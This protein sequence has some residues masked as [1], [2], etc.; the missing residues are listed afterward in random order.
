MHLGT[1]EVNVFYTDGQTEDSETRTLTDSWA[2]GLT[3]SQTTVT[4]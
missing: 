1:G 2:N 3:D 4:D